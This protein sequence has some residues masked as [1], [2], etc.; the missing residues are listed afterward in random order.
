MPRVT[1]VLFVLCLSALLTSCGGG[2]S[3]G[4]D[5]T[6]QDNARALAGRIVALSAETAPDQVPFVDYSGCDLTGSC[7][8]S[9]PENFEQLA[10]GPP[11]VGGEW[12]GEVLEAVEILDPDEAQRLREE[13]AETKQAL[14]DELLDI[15]AFLLLYDP[16]YPD[17][18]GV[19]EHVLAR[20]P[21]LEDELREVATRLIH[22]VDSPQHLVVYS[23]P[24][25]LK[26]GW[27]RTTPEDPESARFD[28]F[29]SGN[30][31]V[32]LRNVVHHRVTATYEGPAAGLYVT[33]P[34]GARETREGMFTATVMLTA[35]FG[36]DGTISGSVRDF[37]E[38]DLP[39]DGWTVDL[40]SATLGD[41][42]DFYKF[43][44]AVAGGVDRRTWDD[45]NWTGGFFRWI[46][47]RPSAVL[48]EFHAAT[49]TPQVGDG[50]AGFIGL[51]GA[52]GAHAKRE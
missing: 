51:A 45:G 29:T 46:H 39:L 26:F 4:T 12:T 16:P 37:R 36:A 22:I 44:G 35:D 15:H 17:P 27:W 14:E 31:R 43:K 9:P 8:L 28:T 11:D 18:G 38:G 42:T 13:L 3:I 10:T 47:G 41:G 25:A 21:V 48:G 1:I 34:S 20:L 7:H 30:D 52:F 19:I 6:Y 2:S 50:D 5:S 40:M 24:D 33:R 49:G 32:R 23:H